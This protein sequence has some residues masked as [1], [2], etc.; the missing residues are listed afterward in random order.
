MMDK[1]PALFVIDE[2][3][4]LRAMDGYRRLSALIAVSAA[5][6]G[7]VD[8]FPTPRIAP[9]PQKVAEERRRLIQGPKRGRW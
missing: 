9:H 2:A 1:H 3:T 6:V 8:A 5:A 7:A 4:H